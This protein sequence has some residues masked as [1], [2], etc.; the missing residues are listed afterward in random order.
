MEGLFVVVT[1]FLLV[2]ITLYKGIRLVPQGSK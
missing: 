1:I 2:I